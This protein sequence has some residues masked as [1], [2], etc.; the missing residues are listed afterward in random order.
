MYK[1]LAIMATGMVLST[2][3]FAAVSDVDSDGDGVASFT[4]LLAV[5]PTLTEEGFG[6][7]DANGDGVV[8]EA[9]MAAA[10]DAGLI[11]EA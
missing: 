5:Y 11:P 1:A 6:T 10:I 9:E 8:D 7:I 2:G 4:E 3:A